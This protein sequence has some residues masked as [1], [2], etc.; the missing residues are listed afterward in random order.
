MMLTCSGGR[1]SPRLS[2]SLFAP[3]SSPVVGL[4]AIPTVFRRPLANTRPPDP[5]GSNRV[6]AARNESRSSQRLQEEP[7]ARYSFPSGPK[8]MVRVEWPPL[9][10]SGTTV[11]GSLR[12]GSNRF[13]SCTSATYIV[14]P[15]K[16]T[17]ITARL[18]AARIHSLEGGD[19]LRHV[20]AARQRRGGRL[21]DLIRDFGFDRREHGRG[22]ALL[23]QVLLVQADRIAFAPCGKQIGRKRFPRLALIVGR[24]SAHAE[25]FSEKQRRSVA[26]AAACGGDPG[27]GIRVEHV[28]A[29]ERRAPDPVAGRPVLE[30]GGKMMLIETGAQR[31]L[32]VFDD[33]N[34]GGAP[35][36]GEVGALLGP[37]G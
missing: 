28:V 27:R 20:V 13:T 33:E 6:T 36:G 10:I 12:P 35:P 2:R 11:A 37:R 31:H 3:H 9:G 23:L 1:S 7:T 19:A 34:G 17:T 8:R 29:V 18:I 24:V 21:F 26:C 4:N 22:D 32:V 25:R 16:A 5:L 15:R 14:S 30:V